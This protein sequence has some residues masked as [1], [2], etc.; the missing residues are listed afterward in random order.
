M[1]AVSL[2]GVARPQLKISVCFSYKVSHTWLRFDF[3]S[4]GNAGGIEG[5]NRVWNV[6]LK[7]TKKEKKKMTN[8][9][10]SAFKDVN[11]AL[12]NLLDQS[13]GMRML[14]IV[15]SLERIAGK[16]NEM[17]HDLRCDIAK[18]NEGKE[19]PGRHIYEQA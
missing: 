16:A 5:R 6:Y 13:D 9:F 18:H 19:I 3:G 10:E 4:L 7:K 1:V 14:E 17:I 2:E 11:D 12:D 8:E 15:F